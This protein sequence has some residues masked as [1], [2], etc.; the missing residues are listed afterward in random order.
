MDFNESTS[1]QPDIREFVAVILAG[2]GNEL[3]PLSS[4]AGGE[5]SPKAL[6]PIANQPMLDF[7]LA[8]LE[9]S[10][11]KD[12]ILIC[13]TAQRQAISHYIHSGSS[14]S[15]RINLH[16]FEETDDLSVGT[17]AILRHFAH[18]I[19][20][21]FVVLPCDF[22]PP[23]S[24]PLSRVLDK[25][26]TESV[27]DGCIATACWFAPRRSEKGATPD[28]W[29]HYDLSTPI[30]Y[31]QATGT[32]LHIDTP[33]DIDRDSEE[34]GL[35]I[36]AITK[37]PRTRLSANLQDSHVYVCRRS[38]LDALSEKPNFDSI[39]EEFIPWLCKVQYQRT[40]RERYGTVLMPRTNTLSQHVALQH[41]TSRVPD[42]VL[43]GKSG[44]SSPH[45][46]DMA[47]SLP[48]SPTGDQDQQM[49][50]AS[51]RV[52]LVIHRDPI[53][54]AARTNTLQSYLELNRSFLSK[55]PYSLP[56]DP[57]DRSLIDPKAQ[58][59]SDCIVGESTR[60]DERTTIKRSVIGKHCTIGKMARIVGCVLLDHCVVEDGAKLDNCIM[61]KNTKVGSKA[62]LS[63]CVTQGGFEVETGGAYKNEKLEI[64]EWAAGG[65][66]EG[67]ETTS[68]DEEDGEE[69]SEETEESED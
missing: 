59:S 25:F 16:P 43:D 58:I 48:P 32:L 38:V 45:D 66:S 24:L 36:G 62:S 60:V 30:V 28:E 6:L 49:A 51:L 37:Y 26:R 69:D 34:I 33:D 1:S 29:G 17:C 47:Y 65:G 63:W 61:G 44:V 21:D 13:P 12:V 11:I 54:Y 40:K 10:G 57:K 8:W 7:P 42:E 19:Q 35:R 18:L 52:G 2:F 64:S 55:T 56:T 3:S 20:Q 31:D 41:S 15:L 67:D 39:R 27:S 22:V 9:Q 14:T 5:P 4:D 68:E 46:K 53:A 50:N 23:Q